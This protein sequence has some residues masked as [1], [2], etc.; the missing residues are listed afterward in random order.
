MT[1][2]GLLAIGPPG[3]DTLL[4]VSRLIGPVCAQ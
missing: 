3:T 2:V 1:M 4:I